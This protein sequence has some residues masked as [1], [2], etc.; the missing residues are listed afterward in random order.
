MQSQLVSVGE[1][2]ADFG[3]PGVRDHCCFMKETEDAIRV[4][5]RIG[6]CF[7]LAA[8]P[9]TTVEEKKKLLNFVVVGGGPTG[10]EFSGSLADFIT[11]D[12]KPRYAALAP[13]VR[14]TLLQS[15]QSILTSFQAKLQ[16]RAIDNLS[17]S[18]CDVKLGVRVVR[19]HKDEV[20]LGSGDRIPYGM[21]LWS[22]GNAPSPFTLE[23]MNSIPAQQQFAKGTETMRG[24][25]KIVVDPWQRVVGTKDMLAVGDAC[26]QLEGERLPPTAQVASQQA[27]YTARLMNRGFTLGA[28]GSD[29]P[30]RKGL[31]GN[32]EVRACV[33]EDFVCVAAC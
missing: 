33:S 1:I 19:V 13:Y 7:E 5:R 12:L 26:T 2:P 6:E 28:G 14:I 21:C 20:E 32:T 16:K 17:R 24:L 25:T 15:G 8:S 29:A 9:T 22:A 11:K 31:L 4:R 3:V 23:L 10:V 27:A 30:S 18:G